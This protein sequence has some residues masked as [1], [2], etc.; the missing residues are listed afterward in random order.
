MTRENDSAGFAGATAGSWITRL[1]LVAI[2]AAGTTSTPSLFAQDHAARI[3]A[4]LQQFHE[5]RDFNG[6]V[7]VA[8]AGEVIFKKGFGYANM[9]WRVPNTPETKFRIGS[10]TKQFTAILILQLV[11]ED[12]VEL[13]GRI[14][15]YVPDYPRPQGDLVTIHHLLNHTSGI[16]SYT[17]LQGFMEESTRDPFV[18][19]SLVAIVSGM[20]LEFEAGTRFRYNNSGY[21]L[22]GL[23]IEKVTGKP[24]HV[25]LRERLLDPLDLRD[26]GYDHTRDVQ[27]NAASGYSRTLTGYEVAPYLHS[28]V[29][30]AAGMMYSTV[31]DLYRW[32]RAIAARD[33]RILEDPASWERMFTPGLSDYGYGWVIRET[34]LEDDGPTVSIIQ[35]GG[36]IFGFSTAFRRFPDERNT[37][38]V[39]DNTTENAGAVATAITRVLYDLPV[40]PPEPSIA[41][42][43][44]PV[45]ENAGADAGIQRY[46]DLKRRSPDEY[47]FSERELDRLGYY[48]LGKGQTEAA[49]KV[50]RLNVGAYPDA[51]NPYDSLGEALL[52]VGDTVGAIESYLA[53]LERNPGNE[54]AVAVLEGLDVSVERA[55]LEGVAVPVEILDR[56]VGEYEINPGFNL[57]VRREGTRLFTQATGQAEFEIFATSNTLWFAKAFD[58][59]L[60]FQVGPNGPAEAVTLHQGGQQRRARRIQ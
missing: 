40:D 50:F 7:L 22:L 49:V 35:H 8:E 55:M 9:E 52:A 15:D 18:P 24:Y 27:S 42:R 29:P 2:V 44:L 31:E 21:F 5:T 23:I 34:R 45:I 53:S 59:Q 28:S 13:D 46:H 3:D 33:E 38:I 26:T 41:E 43:I 60:E 39:M 16:P 14:T 20:P 58:A 37:V 1:V 51:A 30:Y 6:S 57:T 32:D 4:T 25:V 56:Y 47:D 10:V 19:D 36:G 11:E 48:L 54:N 12:V 17:G